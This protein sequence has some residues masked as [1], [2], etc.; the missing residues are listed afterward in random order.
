[1][2]NISRRNI[3]GFTLVEIL[4]VVLIIGILSAVAVPMYQG[5]VDKTHFSTMLSPTRTLKEAQEAVRMATGNYT[6][7]TAD[8]DVDLSQEALSYQIKTT[9]NGDEFNV[10]LA[11]NDKLPNVR[12]ARYLDEN[13]LLQGQLHCE[14]KIGDERANKLCGPL[15]IGQE[16]KATGD[17]YMAYL[18]DE[19]IDQPT[20]DYAGK[21]FST[22]KTKCYKDDATRCDALG[23]NHLGGGQCGFQ[24]ERNQ[25]IDA[26]EMCDGSAAGGCNGS[27][28]SEGGLCEGN[29]QDS[30]RGSTINDGGTCIATGQGHH[31]AC[32][33]ST[34]NDG[35]VCIGMAQD[36][37]EKSTINEGGT[38]LAQGGA[39]DYGA[40]NFICKLATLN[41]GKCIGNS[42][43]SDACSDSIINDKGV[44]EG[45]SRRAC[46]GSTIN[47][48]GTCIGNNGS[49]CTNVTVNDGGV[50]EANKKGACTGTYN[51][52]GCCRGEHC[53]DYAPQC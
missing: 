27:I 48:G 10:I 31:G 5:A 20:C 3:G 11:T 2:K 16:I 30:C 34:V 40:H 44:C 26:E 39:T 43:G 22:S 19:E 8:L 28:V 17:G 15:L 36:G 50:C 18:L 6:T 35:G 12:L 32:G 9:A 38:C 42:T 7:D 51:G 24:D 29:H 13:L 47:N 25:N 1:M 37:C 52:T 53:P 41:G 45:Y 23:S 46:I 4:V 33:R 49:A 21:S 14:A